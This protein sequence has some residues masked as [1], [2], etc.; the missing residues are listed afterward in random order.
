MMFMNMYDV[1]TH[2][3]IMQVKKFLYKVYIHK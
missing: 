2:E 3:G 1:W